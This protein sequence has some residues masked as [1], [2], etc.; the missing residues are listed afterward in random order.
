VARK[1]N[2]RRSTE[3]ETLLGS[4][5]HRAVEAERRRLGVGDEVQDWPEVWGR[6]VGRALG[7]VA[8]IFLLAWL[9]DRLI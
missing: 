6:R 9:A 3:G 8:L 5:A 4:A 1:P 2:D 7:W